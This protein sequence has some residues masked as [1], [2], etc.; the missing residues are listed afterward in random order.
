[1][2]AGIIGGVLALAGSEWALPQLG[3]QGTTSRL[4]DNTAAVEHRLQALEKKPPGGDIANATSPLEPRL[5]T[6]EKSVQAIPA[7]TEKQAQLVA[8]TKAALAANARV[9]RA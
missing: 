7:L 6:L 5:A 4:A 8:E 2:T 3:I 9:L 1:M